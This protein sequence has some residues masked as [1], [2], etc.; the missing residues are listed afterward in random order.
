M[1]KMLNL[2]EIAA[3][4]KKTVKFG[5]EEYEIKPMSVADFVELSKTEKEDATPAEQIDF[6]LQMIT[7]V[8][9]SAPGDK[10]KELTPEQLAA[11]VNFIQSVAEDGADK[12]EEGK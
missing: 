4:E 7:R 5:G 10:L 2:D 12:V 9:P 6:M 1:A 8:I 3:V 11:L